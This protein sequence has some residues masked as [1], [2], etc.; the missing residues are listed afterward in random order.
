LKQYP[1]LMGLSYNSKGE[2][3]QSLAD[4]K[5]KAKAARLLKKKAKK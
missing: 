4:K 1:E 3:L 5:A 2:H